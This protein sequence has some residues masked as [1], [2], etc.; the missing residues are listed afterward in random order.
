MADDAGQSTG[1][2]NVFLVV[3][4]DVFDRL[5]GVVQHLCVGMVDEAVRMTVLLR[6]AIPTAEDAIGPARVVQIP[7]ERWPWTYMRRPLTPDQ[8]L[9]RAGADRPHIVHCM[10]MD[11]ARWAGVW[12]RTWN[13][14]LVVHVTDLEDI[15]EFSRIEPD[16]QTMAVATTDTLAEEL[17]DRYPDHQGDVHVVPLGIPAGTDVVCLS[18][19]ERVPTAVV[20]TPLM[21]DCG[22]D[23]VLKALRAVVEAGREVQLFVL[24]TGPAERSFRQQADDLGI[25]SHV[26]FAGRLGDWTTMREAMRGSDFYILPSGRRRFTISTLTAMANGLCVLAPRGTIGDYL[27]ADETAMLFDPTS[28]DELATKWLKLLD[29]PDASR[30]VAEGALGHIRTYHQASAMAGAMASL[31]RDATASRSATSRSSRDAVVTS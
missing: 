5:G 7:Q 11:L 4:D 22:L 13:R 18:R 19:P 25:R 16:A 1:P 17:R 27:V 2:V 31:Y 21:R 8:V 9:A 28:A 20:T 10:S 6:C 15:R 29:D 12:A 23:V 14:P 3:D 26:T 30:R 24:A